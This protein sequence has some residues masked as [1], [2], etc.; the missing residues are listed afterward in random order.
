MTAPTTKKP[1]TVAA[2][3]HGGTHL[4][5][6]IIR[7]L[8]GKTVYSPKGEAALHCIASPIVVVF[9]R[10]PRNR[11]IS[12][13]RYKMGDVT[14]GM[15]PAARD[16]A[17]ADFL[18]K[19]KQPGS[20]LPIEY[21]IQWD[22]RWSKEPT[23]RQQMHSRFETIVAPEATLGEI[24][25]IASLLTAA[26]LELEAT[27][28]EAQT[29]ALG[30]SGTFTGRHSNYREW[31]GPLACAAWKREFGPALTKRMGYAIDQELGI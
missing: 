3:R 16:Q 12:N 15:A 9:Y 6:P 5:T 31:F 8:T 2:L 20:L 10:D 23:G 17:L 1:I 13:L 18:L 29:Y 30:T 4:I 24:R 21:M 27:P 26:G 28:E 14:I 25:R 7:K 22:Q 11:V 19:R